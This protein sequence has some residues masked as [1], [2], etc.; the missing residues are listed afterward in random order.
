M[1]TPAIEIISHLMN[2]YPSYNPTQAQLD[3]YLDALAPYSTEKLQ[4]AAHAW[5]TDPA[6]L[7][8]NRF[9]PSLADLLSLIPQDIDP[10]DQPVWP[11]GPAVAAFH[12]LN[13]IEETL[14]SA[15]TAGCVDL[16]AWQQLITSYT[17][18]NRPHRAARAAQRLATYHASS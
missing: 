8:S 12:D 14:I 13:R 9:F 1:N 10:A 5:H 18:Q 17:A 4:A 2:L 15:S 7:P 6:H 16:N 11:E 3:A